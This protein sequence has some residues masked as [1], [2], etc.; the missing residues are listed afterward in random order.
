MPNA[1]IVSM[2]VAFPKLVRTN[3]YWRERTPEL[4]AVAETK[5][6][7]KIWSG[8]DNKPKDAFAEA[9]KPFLG[10]PFR[11]SKERR[12]LGPGES[13]LTLEARAAQDAL[14]AAKLNP[15]D[16]E[17]TIVT[18]FV[19]DQ[20]GVGNAP[21]LAAKLGLGGTSFNLE[22]A[23]SSALAGL[24]TA[25]AFVRAG[26]YRRVLVVSSCT[27]SRTTDDDD[28]ISWTAADG[29]SAFVVA[30]CEDGQG[31]VGQKLS[32]TVETV[33]SMYFA[34]VHENN[35]GRPLRLRAK[36]TAGKILR[37]TAEPFMRRCCEGAM[38]DAGVSAADLDFAAVATPTAWYSGFAAR[39]LGIPESKTINTHPSYANIGPVLMPANLF[40]AAHQQLIKP[41]NL[42]LLYSVGSVSSAG[43]LLVRWG[44]VKLGPAPE[45]GQPET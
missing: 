30:P 25:N 9:M 5:S 8:E 1:N 18:S 35:Q 42:V 37:D 6:T 21:H 4:L 16:V 10:D 39:V 14:A 11:G 29:A 45:P 43:A 27:Y 17:L 36:P 31:I 32:H 12:V 20:P 23:C 26:I 19:P 33:E 13:A 44:D 40:H 34:M 38:R 22:T 24:A 15:A 2:A 7:A 3:Q 28:T 41:G